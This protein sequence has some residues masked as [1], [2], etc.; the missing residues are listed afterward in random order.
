MEFIS[1]S[2]N[3]EIDHECIICLEETYNNTNHACG[4]EHEHE[5]EHDNNYYC[6]SNEDL[7]SILDLKEKYDIQ[8]NCTFKI[9]EL[10]YVQWVATNPSC[11]ICHM[12]LPRNA[13]VNINVN[14][15]MEN[16]IGPYNN[17]IIIP[18]ARLDVD[19]FLNQV[20][21]MLTILVSF[22]ITIIVLYLIF[23]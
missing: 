2:L 5:H 15:N 20:L 9:H 6:N 4:Y 23:R 8:C 3:H 16:N 7:I 19:R 1:Y 22:I 10:C 18:N 14:M 17:P 12:R 11:P 21:K 13:H